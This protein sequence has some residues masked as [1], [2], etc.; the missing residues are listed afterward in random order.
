MILTLRGGKGGEKLGTSLFFGGH[1]WSDRI[2]NLNRQGKEKGIRDL[3]ITL[4]ECS[5]SPGAW[6]SGGKK[7]QAKGTFLRNGE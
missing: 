3:Q 1:K 7:I 2:E 6:G 5:D 4:V